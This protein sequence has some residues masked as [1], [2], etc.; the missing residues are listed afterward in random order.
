MR[1]GQYVK[2]PYQDEL[3][4]DV[5]S[6]LALVDPLLFYLYYYPVELIEDVAVPLFRVEKAFNNV[7]SLL[8]HELSLDGAVEVEEAELLQV[9]ALVDP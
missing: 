8:G 9:A 3:V 2:D 5:V 1:F 4:V 6:R 7:G